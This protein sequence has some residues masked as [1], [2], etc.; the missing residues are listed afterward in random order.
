[1]IVATVA[2]GCLVVAA[3]VG[4]DGPY[5]P[6]WKSLDTRP[7]PAW[8]D[9]AKFGIFIHWG[10][11]SAPAYGRRTESAFLW[12][13][14]HDGDPDTLDYLRRNYPPGFTY[15]DFGPMFRAEFYDP[16]QWADIFKASGAK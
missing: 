9:E 8:F 16:D 3:G 14:W 2:L 11:F 10:V 5:S 13:Y 12:R 1:M 15:A 6:T 4:A 7:T